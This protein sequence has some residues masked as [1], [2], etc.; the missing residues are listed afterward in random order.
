MASE[1]GADAR[2]PEMKKKA[3][4]VNS[5][6]AA[7]QAPRRRWDSLKV[8][9]RCC[10]TTRPRSARPGGG[11]YQ[12][13]YRVLPRGTLYGDLDSLMAGLIPGGV[14]RVLIKSS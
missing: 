1:F 9:R 12:R 2:R 11:G 3:G 14:L 8:S 6:P 13:A 5:C 4:A 7:W 10:R